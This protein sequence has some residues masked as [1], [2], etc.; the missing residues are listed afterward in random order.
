MI[1][2]EALVE[3][4]ILEKEIVESFSFKEKQFLKKVWFGAIIIYYFLRRAKK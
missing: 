1:K 2:N 3:K 4:Q